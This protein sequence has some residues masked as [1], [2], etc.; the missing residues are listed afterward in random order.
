MEKKN[1]IPPLPKGYVIEED[2]QELPPLPSGYTI[3]D[4]PSAL[5]KKV[6]PS[7]AS[8][9]SDQSEFVAPIPEGGIGPPLK[10]EFAQLPESDSAVPST[11]PGTTPYSMTVSNAPA[12]LNTSGAGKAKAKKTVEE[13][14]K[15]GGEP[16]IDDYLNTAGLKTAEHIGEFIQEGIQGI[17]SGL[18]KIKESSEMMGKPIKMDGF[19]PDMPV[20]SKKLI[21]ENPGNIQLKGFIKGL[22]G[23]GEAA[24]SAVMHGTPTGAIVTET[25]KAVEL[26][27]GMERVTQTLFAPVSTIATKANGEPL[28]GAAADLAQVADFIL[29]LGAP[30]MS[31]EVYKK[32]VDGQTLSAAEM[33]EAVRSAIEGVKDPDLVRQAAVKTGLKIKP[34]TDIGQ[35]IGESEQ[36]AQPSATPSFEESQKAATEAKP[37]AVEGVVSEKITPEETAPKP[38]MAAT[39]ELLP[40]EEVVKETEIKPA[41]AT[42]EQFAK[43]PEEIKV[44]EE[45]KVSKPELSVED[46]NK[47]VDTGEISTEHL[48]RIADK[49]QGG[50]KLS[51]VEKAIY[52]DKGKEVESLISK[53]ENTSTT[54]I[55]SEQLLEK[56]RNYNMA[57]STPDRAIGIVKYSPDLSFVADIPKKLKEGWQKYFAKEGDLPREVFERQVQMKGETA[58]LAHDLSKNISDFKKAVKVDFKGKLSAKDVTDLNEALM[59][60]KPLE[61]LPPKTR[62][63][64]G[65]MRAHVDKLSKMMIDN[66]LVEGKLAATIQNNLGAY[67]TRSYRVHDVPKWVERV[68]FEVVNRAKSFIRNA[69]EQKGEKLTEDQIQGEI[70][71]LLYKYDAETPLSILAGGKL[72]SK[73]LSILKKRGDIAPEIRALW[74]EYNDPLVN[75]AK[76]VAKMSNLISRGKFLNDVKAMGMDKFLFEKPNSKHYKEIAAEGSKAMEPLNGLY[77]TPEIK[78]AFEEFSKG[79]SHGKLY[80]LYMKA[81]G[82]AKYA[83]TIL[84]F[85]ITHVRNFSANPMIHV[86]RNSNYNFEALKNAAQVVKNEL[87]LGDNKAA[88]EKYKKYTELGITEEGL[89]YEDIKA[90]IQDAN[91]STGTFESL[92]DNIA[93]RATK[94]ITG[95][96]ENLYKHEDTVWK[97]YSFEAE[98]AKYKSAFPEMSDAA[99]DKKAAE[100]VRATTPTYSEVPEAIRN[101]RKFPLAGTFVSFP[102]EI[103]RTTFNSAKLAATE[104]ADP[105]TRSIGAKRMAGTLAAL[106]LWQGVSQWS[107]MTNNID[108]KQDRAIRRFLPEWMK[109][110]ELVYIEN[111]KNGGY[112]ILDAANSD[113]HNYLKKPM[114]AMMNGENPQDGFIDAMKEL[115]SPFL[116]EEMLASK[117]IDIARNTTKTGSQVYNE[118]DEIGKQLADQWAYLMKA[119]EPGNAAGIR[120]I[121]GGLLGQIDP[122]TGQQYDYATEAINQLTGQKIYNINTAKALQLKWAKLDNDIG[123]AKKIYNSVYYSK[124]TTDQDRKEALD[125][126]NSAINKILREAHKDYQAAVA[127]GVNVDEAEDILGSVRLN[128]E[129]KEAVLYG[130][131]YNIEPKE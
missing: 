28:T 125:R 108:D 53:P 22:A 46:Y 88:R 115:L 95:T 89:A 56:E 38:E 49:I 96:L 123:E 29:L 7:A 33:N 40:A 124:A 32:Y 81:N 17:A 127:L 66:G 78:A 51:M 45:V 104:L 67:L 80:S 60:Q 82:F 3:E 11:S 130:Y 119:F 1:T 14:R 15:E 99:L 74:G 87:T 97:I 41:D 43:S 30:K 117:I 107:R 50:E 100:I 55:P 111:S 116:S 44:T 128:E 86:L 101:L 42:A 20:D 6:K 10:Q 75:Y 52:S 85:P 91:K 26:I 25:T 54:N 90:T 110:S 47:F 79:D 126:A 9:G 68:P 19:V 102:Y 36:R 118:Q 114:V 122:K 4:G 35:V 37:E 2:S 112:K 71:D 92:E 61:S 69:Y 129:Q 93:K 16:T 83:K 39:E 62:E 5:K 13:I 48:Q 73:D 120:K 103:I 8:D 27:P 34:D 94:K 113:P 24:F 98:R 72:G 65:K 109:N 105:K 23:T 131:E 77:T 58:A 84:S 63:S 18:G 57:E 31:K 76:S 64:I 70:N 121:V 12:S 59:G 21:E 106:T